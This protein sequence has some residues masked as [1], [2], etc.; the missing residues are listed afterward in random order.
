LQLFAQF[1]NKMREEGKPQTQEVRGWELQ[2]KTGNRTRDRLTDPLA[3]LCFPELSTV[4]S[5]F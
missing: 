4:S 5:K 2:N 3:R 1:L